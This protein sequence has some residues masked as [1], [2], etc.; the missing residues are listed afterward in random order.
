MFRALFP[1]V[2]S[3]FGM[4]V[5]GSGRFSEQTCHFHR[6]VPGLGGFSEQ[7]SRFRRF[8]PG[9]GRFSEQT[10]SCRTTLSRASSNAPDA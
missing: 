2:C 5:P 9:S 1:P 4:F 8:V 3:R 7:T 10:S 6:F